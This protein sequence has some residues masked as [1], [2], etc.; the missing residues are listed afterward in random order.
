MQKEQKK[1]KHIFFWIITALSETMQSYW[2]NFV[3]TGNPNGEG[4]PEWKAFRDAPQ[5]VLMLEEQVRT[6]NTDKEVLPQNSIF[7]HNKCVKINT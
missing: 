2:V 5:Q 6:E 3:K 4:L 7:S 1:S